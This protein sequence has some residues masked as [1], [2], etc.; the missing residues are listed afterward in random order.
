MRVALVSDWTAPRVGGVERQIS[1]LA[2]QLRQ[3]GHDVRVITFTPGPP[4]VDRIPFHRL[5]SRVPPGWRALQRGL[6]R[7][8]YELGDPMPPIVEREI[9]GIL[10]RERVE[11]VHGHSFWS[12]LAHVTIRLG[13]RHGTAGVLTSHSLL[14]R[15]GIV[16]LRAADEAFRW[17]RDPAVLTAVSAAAVHDARL[18]SRRSDVRL[19]PNG[20]DTTAW[21]IGRAAPHDR[22][23]DGRPRLVSVM[24]L[25]ARK[26]PA[27]LLRALARV[28][29]DLDGSA[30]RLDVF[31]DGVLR[32]ALERQAAELG[33]ADLVVFHGARDAN[34]IARGLADADLF[35]MPGRREAFGI[36]LAE[37]LASGVP[38]VAMSGSGVGDV[39][40]DGVAGLLARDDGELASCIA[41]LVT[42]D[43]LRTRMAARAPSQAARF[44]WGTVAPLYLE[45]YRDALAR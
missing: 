1:D 23:R 5:R 34:E 27:R 24:R 37:A 6:E 28:R 45:A 22:R 26:S 13:A 25:N 31:G 14:D 8:G 41:R 7:I 19:I 44:D 17:S 38:V 32:G 21:E 15:A 9:E 3:R 12:S 33:I 30:P 43:A 10:V 11:L 2:V 40:D 18:A 4:Q 42:D 29:A 36:A 16:F 20:L 39:V 35:A